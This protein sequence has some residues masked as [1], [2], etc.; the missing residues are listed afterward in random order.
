[1]L[2]QYQPTK[3]SKMGSSHSKR[4]NKIR[5]DDKNNEVKILHD[6]KTGNSE[7]EVSDEALLDKQYTED[8]KKDLCE[9]PE[10]FVL[11]NL[12]MAIMFFKNYPRFVILLHFSSSN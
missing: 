9:N 7:S 10:M 12:L 6:N 2:V 11:N 1:M 8:I 3:E 5:K 4:S